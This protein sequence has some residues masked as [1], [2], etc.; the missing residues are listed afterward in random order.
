MGV[1]LSDR[2]WKAAERRVARALHGRRLGPG[3]DR[4]DVRAGAG[5]WL[6]CEVKTRRALPA[7][8]Q[9]GLGQARHYATA[10]QLPLLVLHQ[11]GARYGEAI[12]CL[13]LADF[14]AWFGDLPGDPGDDAGER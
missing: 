14:R 1:P 8:L 6:C 13:T 4:A 10:E 2:T 7:W 12:I 11:T 5:D 3:A 9:D